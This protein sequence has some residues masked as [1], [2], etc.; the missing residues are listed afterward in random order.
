MGHKISKITTLNWLL[1][2]PYN[3]DFYPNNSAAANVSSV[4]NVGYQ[5]NETDPNQHID[6]NKGSHND[7]LATPQRNANKDNSNHEKGETR[8]GIPLRNIRY[9]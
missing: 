5:P 6:D 2:A 8:Q 1:R 9:E 7:E 4:V 3:F